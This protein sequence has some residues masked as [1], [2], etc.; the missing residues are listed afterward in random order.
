MATGRNEI[1]SLSRWFQSQLGKLRR[2]DSPGIDEIA[3]IPLL[4]VW[5]RLLEWAAGE[6]LADGELEIVVNAAQEAEKQYKAY[7]ATV[8]DAKS[9]AL[10]SMRGNLDVFP[11]L[12]D[13][14]VKRGLPADMFSGFR[15]E[16][17]LAGEE[18]LR[19]QSIV[20]YVTRRM[21]RLDSAVQ[22]ASSSAHLASEALALARKAATETATGALEKSFETTAK[23]SARSAFWFR[24][25]T[26]VTLG[27]TVLF[28]LV[29]AA[30]STVE[31]VDNWQEVVYRVAILSALAG[32]AAYL[33]R[34]ASNYHRIA[35]W[36]RAIE[37]QL[38][39]FLGFINE[40][41]DEEARQTMYTLFARRVLE[42]PPDGKASNDEVTNLI[43]PI[44]DQAVKLRPSP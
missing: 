33:G 23:S 19:S 2:E 44:I 42:A 32:I 16:I 43:Q 4:A 8:G 29:Y 11:A 31:S 27:V 1:E 18:A 22:D 38:K 13:E 37:I 36:A 41:E 39:A 34:Q 9:L 15:A 25:G 28:G 3:V 21:E 14:L 12:F 40:I 35:T 7:L 24:V 30:G 20:A 5:H 6:M 10:V 26:L 17:N